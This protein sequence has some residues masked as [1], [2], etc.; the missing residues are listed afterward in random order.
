MAV[1][2]G[3]QVQPMDLVTK[4][5]RECAKLFGLLLDHYGC[6]E[7]MNGKPCTVIIGLRLTAQ[8]ATQK[9]NIWKL[10]NEIYT[11]CMTPKAGGN[12]CFVL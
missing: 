5:T 2:K 3:S 1:Q 9:F 6:P 8:D 11:Q 10:K 7:E 4:S 12:R